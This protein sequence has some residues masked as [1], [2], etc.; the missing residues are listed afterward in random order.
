ML[1]KQFAIFWIVCALLQLIQMHGNVST[2]SELTHGAVI[3]GRER[4]WEGLSMQGTN[5]EVRIVCSH[6]YRRRKCVTCS[7]NYIVIS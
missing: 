3:S 1:G 4:S 6:A 5:G 7:I 2:L